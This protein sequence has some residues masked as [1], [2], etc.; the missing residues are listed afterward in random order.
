MT[1]TELQQRIIQKLEAMESN[2]LA[3]L[4]SIIDGLNF[5]I[6]P[7]NF[8]F[9]SIKNDREKNNDLIKSL[10]GMASGSTLRSDEFARMKQEE[11]D[12]EDRSQ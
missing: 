10:R 7:Q 2:K 6:Q 9:V 12:W 3:F 8:N 4:D 5:Y 11:I 1:R